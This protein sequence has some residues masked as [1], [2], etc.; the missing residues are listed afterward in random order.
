MTN[1]P[2]R[3]EHTPLTH[4]A[5]A[6]QAFV[7]KDHGTFVYDIE[8]HDAFHEREEQQVLLFKRLVQINEDHHS[9][10]ITEPAPRSRATKVKEA[11]SNE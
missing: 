8:A 6:H 7:C 10:K 2:E 5:I 9:D 1:H 4:P 3:Y 11:T